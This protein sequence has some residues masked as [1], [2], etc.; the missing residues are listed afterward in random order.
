MG[1]TATVARRIGENDPDGAARSRRCRRSRSACS[2]PCRS[3]CSASGSRR[4]LLAL[5]GATP[6]VLA[7]C[8]VHRDPVRLQRRHPDAVPDQRRVPRRRRRRDRDARAVDRQRDQHLPRPL[9]DLRARVRFPRL[10]VTGAAVATTTGR[11]I[12]VLVQLY[13][14]SRSD[15]RIA[16]R[17]RHL[18]LD[19]SVMLNML[20]LSG[21]GGI[22]DVHRHHELHRGDADHRVVRQRRGGRLH[23]R[24]PH[25][26]VRAAAVVGA[27]ERGRD[28]G[29]AESR[30]GQPER[31]ESS[32]WR[33]CWY[34]VRVPRRARAPVRRLRRRRRRLVHA[35]SRGRAD[36][37]PRPS[38][39]QRRL[40]VLCLPATC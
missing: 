13:F 15:G 36:R 38:H 40:P 12:G 16:I 10:G 1:A 28:A 8:L 4:P 9:P 17:R 3:A 22:P 20:R 29:R 30:R 25:H 18:R 19:P 5:M 26:H 7:H 31:A 23:H 37:D 33:A 34:N 39:H 21:S 27:V 32:A 14:L 11:G 2:S 6:D 24:D 35:R